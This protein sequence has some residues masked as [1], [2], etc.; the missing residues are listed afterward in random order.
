VLRTKSMLGSQCFFDMVGLTINAVKSEPMVLFR[1]HHN[2]N[3]ILWINGRSLPQTK[4]F[5]NL[6][7]FFGFGLRWSTKTRY[8]QR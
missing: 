6:G 5:K 2:P 3:V 7:V 1:K 4:Q 8:V